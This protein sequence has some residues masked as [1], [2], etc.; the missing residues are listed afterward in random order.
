MFLIFYVYKKKE[1]NISCYIDI[2]SFDRD[3]CIYNYLDG[4]FSAEAKQFVDSLTRL[5]LVL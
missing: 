5:S 3:Q 1:E 2:N 4:I